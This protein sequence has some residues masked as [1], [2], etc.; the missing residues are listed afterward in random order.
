MSGQSAS[1]EHVFDTGPA[2][3]TPPAG[4]PCAEDWDEDWFDP[5][6][7]DEIPTPP[8]TVSPPVGECAPSG[9]LAL[10][11][12]H[13]S[14]DPT[15][16]SD[17]AL[18]DTMV[19]FDR[20]TSWAGARQAE[21]MAEFARRRPGQDCPPD[22]SDVPARYSG[23]APDEVALALRLSRTTV[24]NRMAMAQQMVAELPATL[25]AWRAGT[26]DTR[27][28]QAI[29]E[30]SYVLS[31]QQC[32]AL[33]ARVLPRAGSQTLAQLR[34][35]LVRAVLAIDP[36]GAARRYRQRR[37]DRRV[38]LRSDQDGMATLWALLSAPDATAAYQRLCD[39]ARSLGADDPRSMDARR[40]DLLTEVLTGRRCAAT[41]THPTTPDCPGG[42]CDCAPDTGTPDT[43]TPDTPTPNTTVPDTTGTSP[44]GASTDPGSTPASPGGDSVPAPPAA[45]DAGQG[46]RC[47]AGAG[48][49]PGK[50]LISVIVPIT[51]LLGLD[52]HPGELVGYGP[53]PAA[54]ARQIAAEGTWRRLLTDPAS[55]TLLDY[56]RTTYT[57]PAG[58]ADFVRARDVYCRN[59]ICGQ[60]A[61]TAD[62][63]HTIA[64]DDGGT[65]NEHNL[66]AACRHDH[67][68]KTFGPG[69][70][71]EQHPDGRVTWTTPT[72]HTYT[73]HPHDYRTH[74]PH[75]PS[76]GTP[77]PGS[78]AGHDPPDDEPPF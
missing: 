34:A 27:K 59:P 30:T 35:A 56:G 24:A 60:R 47:G 44:T 51:M 11:L 62:L 7:L 67:L 45:P 48:G 9:W 63:D 4:A 74:P 73:S 3:E 53:I 32:A 41:G 18:I 77:A 29:T 39:L 5:A 70:H 42:D 22:R 55:G 66:Y 57:P 16:M 68:I 33:E 25:A 78:T 31:R 23:Y 49:G 61:A 8:E 37:Q 2:Q 20:L 38:E 52:E 54:L 71:V 64:W 76:T 13:A 40:A 50:P 10:E 15:R 69:W 65:T 46:H 75:P 28:A 21:L 17:A 12:D 58:L 26:I 19:S 6:W 1:I 43:V 36:D 72:G 14:A